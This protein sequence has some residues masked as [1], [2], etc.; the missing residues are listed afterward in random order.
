MP[1]VCFYFQVHQPFRLKRYTHTDIGTDH[2]YE[3]DVLNKQV[4]D[5]VAERCYLPT[6]KLM[7]ELIKKHKKKF[8]ISYSISG[9]ALEQFEKWRPDVLK[10][11][12]DL[13]KTGCVEFLSE[14][15]N[16][17]LSYLFSKDEFKRQV[18]L[19]AA[20]IKKL[21]GQTPVVF[22]NTE[23]IYFNELAKYAEDMGYKGI[24]CEGVD[25]ILNSRTPNYLYK[26]PN[27]TAIKSLLKNYRLSDD[28][29]FRF[30]DKNWSEHPLTA[31]K[32]AS[33]V[34]NI[35]GNGE[36]VNLFMDYETFGEHQWEESGIFEFLKHLP[37]KIFLHPDFDFLTPSEVIAKYETHG[38]YDAHAPN[39]WADTER[40]LSAWLS[41]NMQQE[42][43][44][45][46]YALETQV[47]GLN[48][49][50]VLAQWARLLT[51]D[52]FYY[53]CTKY[54][55]DGDVHKYFSPYDS[56]YEAYMYY[57]NA[58]ADFE[59]Q[60]DIKSGKG[61]SKKTVAAVTD[62]SKEVVKTPVAETQKIKATETKVDLKETAPQ[63]L[64]PAKVVTTSKAESKVDKK[65]VTPLKTAPASVTPAAKTEVKPVVT[66]VAETAKKE[67][68]A[69][70]ATNKKPEAKPV[71]A[72]VAAKPAPANNKKVVVKK[73]AKK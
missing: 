12:V 36:V 8:R 1:S 37:E 21:F 62:K 57:I 44:A 70:P 22:R 33:W 52:H 50:E 43:M 27:V 24:I 29:A 35:A 31:E 40:D 16:H 54:W 60:L 71:I 42:A 69:I 10:S 55:S 11:F 63:K 3:D 61:K 32:F 13:A 41:N 5:K 47:K 17:S 49:D 45:K 64:A 67:T 48:N 2:L 53:M 56:P 51:S 14:T 59:L 28:V 68:K 7:L 18:E 6:N 9:V 66:K 38:V 58:L 23:L 39:S 72:K 34:H 4:L 65:E 73:A 46:V 19:H 30:S 25:W 15:Y 26:A 20:K